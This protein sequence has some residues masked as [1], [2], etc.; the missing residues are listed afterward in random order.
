MGQQMFTDVAYVQLTGA[1]GAIV[2]NVNIASVTRNG[3]GDYQVVLGE[4]ID[5]TECHTEITPIGTN[6]ICHVVHTSDTSKQLLCE[7]DA[8]AA[9]DPTTLEAK[10]SRLKPT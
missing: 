10:F 6:V 8:G 5:A 7:S 2:Q 3:A 9:T 1:T 4:A